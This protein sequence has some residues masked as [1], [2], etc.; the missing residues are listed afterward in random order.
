ML[1]GLPVGEH[2]LSVR[3]LGYAPLVH[4]VAVARGVTT[5]ATIGLSPD[6]VV[7]APLVAVA[8]RS[9]RLEVS[10]FYERRDWGE[11]T[12]GGEF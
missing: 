3:H 9:R 7:L 5:E 4:R 11:L 10:G 6:P 2:E 8:T 1:S 12:G